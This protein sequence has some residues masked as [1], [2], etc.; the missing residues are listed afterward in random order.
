MSVNH[1]NITCSFKRLTKLNAGNFRVPGSKKRPELEENQCWAVIVNRKTAGGDI[2][3]M[4][5]PT[6][7]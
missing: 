7:L 1:L 4:S 3:T 6:G 2:G 5:G